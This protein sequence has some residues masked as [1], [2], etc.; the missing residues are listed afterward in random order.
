MNERYQY[1][2]HRDTAVLEGVLIVLDIMIV[3]VRICEEIVGSGED[4]RG[5]YIQTRQEYVLRLAY[6]KDFFLIIVQQASHL[7]PEVHRSLLGCLYLYSFVHSYG[8]VVGSNEY[9][10]VFIAQKLQYLQKRRVCEPSLSNASVCFFVFCQLP[11]QIR[12]RPCMREH[13]NEVIH[14]D[15]QLIVHKIRQIVYHSFAVGN[16]QN[17]MIGRLYIEI[18]PLKLFLQE[19]M[20]VLVFVACLIFVQP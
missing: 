18:V 14:Y 20:F 7:I 6:C 1:F 12:F 19:E 9:I 17:F 11:D 15:I 5:K 16:I 2:F 10:H 8:T 13:I 4:I 3:V